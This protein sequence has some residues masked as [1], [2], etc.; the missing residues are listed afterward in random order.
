MNLWVKDKAI[1][2]ATVELTEVP[3]LCY[4]LHNNIVT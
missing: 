4:K 1:G 3:N 2:K